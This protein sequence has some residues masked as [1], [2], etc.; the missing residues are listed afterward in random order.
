LQIPGWI[1]SLPRMTF[2]ANETTSVKNCLLTSRYVFRFS[3]SSHK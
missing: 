2:V 1:V 3:Q